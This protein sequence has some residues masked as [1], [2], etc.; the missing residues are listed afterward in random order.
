[1]SSAGHC[2]RHDM[3]R[4]MYCEDF[5][6]DSYHDGVKELDDTIFQQAEEIKQ[7]QEA[8]HIVADWELPNTGRF[9]NNDPKWPIPYTET[10][11]ND[12]GKQH[13][14]DVARTALEKSDD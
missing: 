9:Y 8:L 12:D 4:C 14:M 11:G 5:H 6:E 2:G 10:Y 13:I 3:Y 7:L 1:M